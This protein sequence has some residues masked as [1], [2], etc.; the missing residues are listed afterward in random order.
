MIENGYHALAVDEHRRNFAP[1]LWTVRKPRDPN[2]KIPP[3]RALSSVEQRWFVGA[4]ANIGGGYE[5]D[6]LAQLPLRWIMKKASLHGLTFRND[7]EIDG[8]FLKSQ[9]G[10]SYREFMGGFYRWIVTGMR[11][12]PRSR[13]VHLRY[14]LA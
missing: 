9:I 7:V 13:E 8:N 12:P 2:V 5:S 6:L 10:D 3:Q 4:H 14:S 1:T 11:P